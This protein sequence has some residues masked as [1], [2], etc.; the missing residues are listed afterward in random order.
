MGNKKWGI[1]IKKKDIGKSWILAHNRFTE[2]R[3]DWNSN[4]EDYGRKVSI[5][6]EGLEQLDYLIVIRYLGNIR[7]KWFDRSFEKFGLGR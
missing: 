5:K 2:N 7:Y 6:E 4:V 1:Q 3:Q